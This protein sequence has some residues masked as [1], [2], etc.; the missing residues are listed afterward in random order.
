[1]FQIKLDLL[2]FIEWPFRLL[3]FFWNGHSGEFSKVLDAG[4]SPPTRIMLLDLK[5][6]FD[7]VPAVLVHIRFHVFPQCL[8]FSDGL[9]ALVI[10]ETDLDP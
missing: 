3:D 7:C 9:H 4:V 6:R 1:M 8:V 5:F 10:S 2:E